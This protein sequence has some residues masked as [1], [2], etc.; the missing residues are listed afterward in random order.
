MFRDALD[1][2]ASDL[3]PRD[4]VGSAAA[5]HQGGCGGADHRQQVKQVWLPL[6]AERQVFE[7]ERQSCGPQLEPVP[8][9]DWP[10]VSPEGAQ[11][12][13]GRC[14]TVNQR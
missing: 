5:E 3:E 13:A 10:R 9:L 7:P 11:D 8:I 2:D 4:L 6:G 1:V 12:D 14:Q